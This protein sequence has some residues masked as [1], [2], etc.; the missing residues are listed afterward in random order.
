MST[1]IEQLTYKENRLTFGS[2]HLDEL[3][4]R[5]GT[6][7]YIYNFDIVKK[8]IESLKNGI[9]SR[10]NLIC[11]ALKSNSNPKLLQFLHNLGI[12]ADVVSGGELMLAR[13][14]GIP[15]SRIVFSGVAKSNEE[16]ALGISEDILSFNVETP[17]EVKRISQAAKSKGIQAKISLRINPN[18]N[19]KTHPKI[20][21]GLYDTKFG[22]DP[23]EVSLQAKLISQDPNLILSGISCHIGSQILDL[24]PLKE[25]AV[26]MRDFAR[27]L[28]ASGH[29]LTHID[30]GGGLG[31]AYIPEDTKKAVDLESYGQMIRD[32]FADDPAT[33]VFE[34]GRSIVAESGIL[35]TRVIEVKKNLR[36]QFVLIDVGMNDLIRPSIYDAYHHIYTVWKKSSPSVEESVD[37]VGPVCETGDYIALD[38]SLTIPKEGEYL[39]I[40][41]AGAYGYSMSS[42][43][44]TRPRPAEIAINSGEVSLIRKRELI[45]DLID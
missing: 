41:H 12:G 4:T 22:L 26:F 42:N 14:A 2:V 28:R 18:I 34:P 17:G 39:A 13:K 9:G 1:H 37:I 20:A 32:I 15:P 11:F 29:Q 31:V 30:V 16:I 38:R 7:L 43:Y 6:P 21:T 10:S 36:K 23:N 44:N 3:A 27:T 35:L 24:N 5:F 19:A 8:R 45:K 33:I 40:C 25:A